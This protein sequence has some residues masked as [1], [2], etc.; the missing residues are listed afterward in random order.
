MSYMHCCDSLEIVQSTFTVSDNGFNFSVRVT[1]CKNCG[2]K[3]TVGSGVSDGRKRTKSVDVD[4][5]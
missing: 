1:Y 3:K 2:S 5:I 4:T